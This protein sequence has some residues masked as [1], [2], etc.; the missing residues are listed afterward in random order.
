MPILAI[1]RLTARK[2]VVFHCLPDTSQRFWEL[3]LTRS[4]FISAIDVADAVAK[5]W[6]SASDFCMAAIAGTEQAGSPLNAFTEICRDHAFRRADFIDQQIAER[7]PVGPLCGVPI[8][9]KDN[10]CTKFARTTCGSRTLQQFQPPSAVLRSF[11]RDRMRQR[12]VQ[13]VPCLREG[14]I[15]CALR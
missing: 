12:D 3:R 8:A 5:G 2:L 14:G 7:R 6:R 11:R 4:D 1:F 13:R 9:I 15:C 10:I